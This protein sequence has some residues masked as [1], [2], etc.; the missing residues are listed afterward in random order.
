MRIFAIMLAVFFMLTMFTVGIM[1]VEQTKSVEIKIDS[2][3]IKNINVK[4]KCVDGS[5]M[6]LHK[7]NDSSEEYWFFPYSKYKGHRLP[8]KG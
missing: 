4:T 8:C 2:A 7:V 3:E 5:L 6:I 1:S